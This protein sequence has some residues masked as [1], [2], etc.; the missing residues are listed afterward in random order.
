MDK[1][2]DAIEAL[3]HA[4]G[5]L[6]KPKNIEAC[7]CCADEK[8]LDL[9]RA[10]PL[11]DLFSDDLGPYA[12][13]AFLTIGGV[14]DYLYFLPRILEIHASDID[15][16]PSPEIT[17]RAIHKTAPS[18]WPTKRSDAL[19]AFLHSLFDAFIREDCSGNQIDSW[20]CAIAM[21][22][23]DTQPYLSQIEISP[24]HVLAY[25]RKNAGKLGERKLSNT[26]WEL[27]I[28]GYDQVIHWFGTKT[29][30]DII[31]DAYGV[32]LHHSATSRS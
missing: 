31:F 5:D 12:A 29:V 22:G 7:P 15:W 21:S 32:S 20:I 9:L 14:S 19:A 23:L 3:Y 25:Y 30:S 28:P 6:P 2:S 4:F 27:P 1:L 24:D 8:N 18:S 17:G 26:F 13:S 10:K 11:R 16:W